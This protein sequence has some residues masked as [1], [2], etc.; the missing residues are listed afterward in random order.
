MDVHLQQPACIFLVDA[1]ITIVSSSTLSCSHTRSQCCFCKWTLCVSFSIRL[2]RSLKISA[3]LSSSLTRCYDLPFCSGHEMHPPSPFLSL[4]SP[5]FHS[6][7]HCSWLSC[8]C[9]MSLTTTFVFMIY[10][11]FSPGYH[12][13]LTLHFSQK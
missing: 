1:S 5:S 2:R 6:I 4:P 11:F 10:R 12:S 9:D 8:E 7:I 3:A 13:F